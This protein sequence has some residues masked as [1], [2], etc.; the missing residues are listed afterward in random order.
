MGWWDDLL[1]RRSDPNTPADPNAPQAPQ[2]QVQPGIL[3]QKQDSNPLGFLGDALTGY[4]RAVLGNPEATGGQAAWATLGHITNSVAAGMGSPVGMDY[5]HR[6]NS[7]DPQEAQLRALQLENEKLDSEAKRRRQSAFD[8]LGA[9]DQ[10]DLSNPEQRRKVVAAFLAA[11]DTESA[12]RIESTWGKDTANK[13]ELGRMIRDRAEAAKRGEGTSAYDTV[14]QN[15]TAPAAPGVGKGYDEGATHYTPVYNQQTGEW[16]YKAAPRKL[17]GAGRA[18]GVRAGGEPVVAVEGPDG[19][20]LLVPRSKAAGMRPAPHGVKV[21][22]GPDGKRKFVTTEEARGQEP[23]YAPKPLSAWDVLGQK[24]PADAPPVLTPEEMK[25]K[26]DA[27]LREY[28][29]GAR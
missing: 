25:K 1:G 20:P 22:V 24:N 29:G 13:S 15:K 21:V 4:G 9:Q 27:L 18:G 28:M 23:A 19:R 16:E 8:Q 26:S 11:G 14:I 7:Q 10:V 12:A 17:P 3:G 2:P 5:L 6:F